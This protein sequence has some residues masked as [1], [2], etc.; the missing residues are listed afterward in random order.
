MNRR[1]KR[2]LASAAVILFLFLLNGTQVKAPIPV[3]KVVIDNSSAVGNTEGSVSS[4]VWFLVTRVVDGDTIELST[5]D[6]VRYVGVNTPESVD[7]RRP[8]Q[9]FG[10]E[11]SAYNKKLVLDKKVRLEKDVSETDRYGRLL[12]FVY[13]EDGTF[14]NLKLVED[15]YANMMTVAPDVSKAELFR[16]SEKKARESGVGLWGKCR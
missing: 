1:M 10:K 13:L 2:A 12:R 8:V 3:I 11:A 6:K 16:A 7:P 9:C 14:V 15:G 4:T 5:G